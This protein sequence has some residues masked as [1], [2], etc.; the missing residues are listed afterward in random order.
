MKG[1]LEKEETYREQMAPIREIVWRFAE[2]RGWMW[3]RRGRTAHASIHGPIHDL[4]GV[5]DITLERADWDQMPDELS[6]TTPINLWASAYQDRDGARHFAPLEL[7]WEAPFGD[8]QKYT[9]TFLSAAWDM[10]QGLRSKE[11]LKE[12]PGSSIPPFLPPDFGPP[13]RRGG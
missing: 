11:L 12:R 6:A 3:L 10:L 7:R 5:I 4:E 2:P 8:L 1:I 13:V 9:E